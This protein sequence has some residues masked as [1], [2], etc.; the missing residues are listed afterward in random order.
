MEAVRPQYLPP[1]WGVDHAARRDFGP[2]SVYAA[3]RREREKQE[4]ARGQAQG[5]ALEDE[6]ME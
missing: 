1:A 4:A 3:E 5:A 2:F 6:H